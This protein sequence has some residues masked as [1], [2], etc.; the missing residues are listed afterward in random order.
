VARVIE[1]NLD[2][3]SKLMALA[4]V[5]EAVT[6]L[7]L[8]V[9]PAFVVGLLLS[10]GAAGQTLLVARCF[11]IALLAL[12]IACLPGAIGRSTQQGMLT[13]N[14]LIA[15]FLAYVGATQHVGGVLLWPA[16]ALHAV[17]A[18]LLIG[19]WR[20]ERWTKMAE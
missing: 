1:R 12:A 11:G 13:Y 8:I 9:A 2:A 6:G 17:V 10:G 16:V 14:V 7:A 18:L 15:L 19:I 4:A 20:V 5:I 3:R